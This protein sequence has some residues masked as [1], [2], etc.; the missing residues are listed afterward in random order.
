MPQPTIAVTDIQRA[1]RVKGHSD[2]AIDGKL[3]PKTWRAISA[4]VLGTVA[5]A[6]EWTLDRRLVAIQQIIMRDVG[7]VVGKIDGLLGPQTQF[8]FEKWQDHL[9]DVDL[10]EEEVVARPRAWPRQAQAASAFGPPGSGQTSLALP[11]PM[12]LAWDPSKVVR[13][14]STHRLVAASAGRALA[15]VLEH[16]GEQRIRE[17]RL[18]YWGGCLNVRPMRG[19]SK[20]S[21]HSYG[22]AIDFDPERNQLRWGRDRAELA[23]PAYDAFWRAW[24]SE[25]WTSLGRQRNYD[26]MHVQAPGL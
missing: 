6:K 10:P 4:V 18:D 14:F 25:G 9:R 3:G 2:I 21:M 11:Y 23:Q 26:W 8:A 22:V 15:R 20:P 13:S 24:E 16:Y 19:G 12:R 17:L 1:L 7:I 5:E